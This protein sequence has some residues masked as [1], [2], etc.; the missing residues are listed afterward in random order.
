MNIKK[1]KRNFYVFW[2]IMMAL[3]LHLTLL[4]CASPGQEVKQQSGKTPYRVPHVKLKAHID[5][6]LDDEI[7]QEALKLE[8]KYEVNPGENIEAL[9]KTEAFFA[10]TRQYLYIAFR[11]YDP[12]PSAIRANISERDKVVRNDFVG[13]VLDT[14]NDSRNSYSFLCNPYGVQSDYIDSI[15][16][17]N[18]N[19][20]A[21]W[22][23]AGKIT[24]EGYNVE[25]AIPFSSIR[26]QRIK[27]DQ[28][29]GVDAVRV[30]PRN[31]SRL[32]GLFP[33]DR[34]N[35][36]YM[37]QAEKLIGFSGI[38]RE[39]NIEID[40]TI[41]GHSTQQRESFPNG[42]FE[43]KDSKVEP[44]VTAHWSFTP[45]LTLSAAANPDF[46]NI[47]A[48]VAQLD[49]NKQ[50]ALFY[51]EKRPF[52]LE[53][54]D[55]F[56]TRYNIVYTRSLADPIGGIKITGKEGPHA[57]GFFS[58]YDNITNLLIPGSQSSTWTALDCKTFGSALR[59]RRDIGKASN[60]GMVAS[61]REGS[62]ND[63]F[64]RTFGFDGNLRLTQKDRI[65][66]QF[67]GSQ[68]RY[69]GNISTRYG[70]P[71]DA[72]WG[73]AYD[74]NYLHSTRSFNWFFDYQ[75]INPDFRAD[76]GF[77]FQVDYR[78]TSGGFSY[79]WRRKPGSWFTF[80]NIGSSYTLEKNH[81]NNLLFQALKLQAN[82]IGPL[83]TF[84]DLNVNIG[85]RGFMGIEFD[86]N[87]F[88]GDIGFIPSQSLALMIAVKAGDQI[89]T[90]NV[91]PGKVLALSPI[92]RMKAGTHLAM[93]ITHD[94]EKFV[95]DD[96]RLYTANL[97]NLKVVYQFDKRTFLRTILQYADHK[98]N[99]ALY[100]FA[101]TPRYRHLFSQIL[102]SYTINPQT[103]LFI[104]YSDDHYG[105]QWIDLTQNNRT[106]FVKLGYALRL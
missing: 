55:I 69:P 23:S 71:T 68:T 48:D 99:A 21:I 98:F 85:K 18:A 26:F 101:I 41:S 74:V 43:K 14:F 54:A 64:N 67:L 34:N 45:N 58:V 27:G 73:A 92:L 46:S 40:P 56:A 78:N 66:F 84:L 79:F 33:R 70:Q 5:G 53:G 39:K 102:F 94:Y 75:V 104:G 3:M 96:G 60:I 17:G 37:C 4:V 91:Q 42:K 9:V 90:Y 50:F 28:I 10:Y 100:P 105:Y 2:G 62:G 59:Y 20:D 63:Y 15:D 82:Y 11:A 13:V 76:L 47:E 106:I 30:Y 95:V 22:Y 29:W 88:S 87:F 61:D 93:D 6:V 72:F 24:A 44:G 49:I 38:S 83:Q 7:W 89:D 86:E 80:I 57:L 1:R 31:S 32:L 65:M 12:D 52:F 16:G 35:N 25:I 81:A 97:T 8:L 103:V 19:W 51:P 36:C 77:I